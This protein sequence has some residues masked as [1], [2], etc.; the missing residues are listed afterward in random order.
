[1][2]Q[3]QFC[4]L[5]QNH[6]DLFLNAHSICSGLFNVNKSHILEKCSKNTWNT[7]YIEDVSMSLADLGEVGCV[8]V[9]W[10]FGKNPLT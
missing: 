8:S 7:G 3:K 4:L 6:P 2:S 10:Q 9:V 5:T 1:M